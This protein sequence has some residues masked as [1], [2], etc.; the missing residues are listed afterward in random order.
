M[1]YRIREL[2]GEEN[3][4]ILA[5]LHNFTFLDSAP[6]PN[7]SNGFWWTATNG[8]EPVAFIG[9]IQSILD[10]YTGYFTRVGVLP[11]HRGHKLQAKLM[12]A[13]EAK[14][15]R[16]GWLRI[17]TDTTDN[18]PSANNIIAAGYRLFDPEHRWSL[19]EALYWQKQL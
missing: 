11:S 1:S 10:E 14:A 13:M 7:F 18:T 8:K 4:D 19:P 17:V 6:V 9:I 15:K 2:D 16:T 5:E 12:R 3:A